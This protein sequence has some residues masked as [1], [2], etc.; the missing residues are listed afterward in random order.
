MNYKQVIG[1]IMGI[2]I[3]A[4]LIACI[5]VLA[6]KRGFGEAISLGCAILTPGVLMSVLIALGFS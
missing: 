2:S 1:L 5:V 6:R 4:A 3:L